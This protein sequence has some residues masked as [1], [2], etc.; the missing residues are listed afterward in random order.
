MDGSKAIT[1]EP[2]KPGA[3]PGNYA[4]PVS[5]PSRSP[6]QN[7]R[8]P[9]EELPGSLANTRSTRR[10]TSMQLSSSPSRCPGQP[11]RPL[12]MVSPGPS[13]GPS[14]LS[15]PASR[16]LLPLSS[17]LSCLTPP[18]VSA[19]LINGEQAS[20]LQSPSPG[21]SHAPTQGAVAPKAEKKERKAGGLLKLLTGAAAKKKPRSPPSSPPTHNPSLAGQG[22]TATDP[23]HHP[24][25][26]H[27][28][29]RSGS[30]PMA[31]QGRAGSLSN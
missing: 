13:L 15:S 29:A 11:G 9:A 17:P 3:F 16:P 12:S 27:H 22:A 19:V 2:A 24:H 7:C 31:S 8:R 6:P 1:E 30:C 18:N 28:H 5:R 23:T 4:T 26:H 20:P 14:P 25:H 21:P 10:R